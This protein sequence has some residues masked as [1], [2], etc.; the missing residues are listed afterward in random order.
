[1]W[2][3]LLDGCW[4]VFQHEEKRESQIVWCHKQLNFFQFVL[5]PFRKLTKTALV[6][7]QFLTPFSFSFSSISWKNSKENFSVD[8]Y[9]EIIFYGGLV[10]TDS[11]NLGMKSLKD[12]FILYSNSCQII[13]PGTEWNIIKIRNGLAQIQIYSCFLSR[14]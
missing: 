8:F 12:N 4:R 10:R 1:M 3:G 13:S 6:F 2:W 9:L 5:T 14:F 11:C 7:K